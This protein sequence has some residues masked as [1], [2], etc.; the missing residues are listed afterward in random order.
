RTRIRLPLTCDSSRGYAGMSFTR[1][2]KKTPPFAG[3]KR[4]GRDR[5]KAEKLGEKVIHVP[6]VVNSIFS[7]KVDFAYFS[8]NYRIVVNKRSLVKRW[9]ESGQLCPRETSV[10]C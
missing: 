2:G 3:A 8:L 6:P 5:E 10:E 7:E 1:Q 4:R 9:T